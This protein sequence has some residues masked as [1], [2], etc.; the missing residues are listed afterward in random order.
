MFARLSVRIVDDRA[1][2]RR[3]VYF[4]GMAFVKGCANGE[5]NNCLINALTQ[6][7]SDH[8]AVI[9]DVVW[10]RQELRQRFPDGPN[11]VTERNFLD[12]RAHW[13]SVVSLISESAFSMGFRESRARIRP[14]LFRVTCV[15]E[16]SSVIGDVVGD[17]GTNLYL[18]N[19]G[20]SHF[21]PLLRRR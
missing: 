17:G 9:V 8:Y 4:G 2:Y 12:L 1:N 3:L 5:D 6:A 7:V 14:E 18:L 13:G 10:I 16:Q 15:D 20:R 21:V 19:E 11:I